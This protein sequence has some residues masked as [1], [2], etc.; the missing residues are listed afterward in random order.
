MSEDTPVASIVIPN[1]NG[2]H[3][4]ARCLSA[5]A[6]QTYQ[7]FECV[8]VD[9]G[10]VDGSCEFL[11]AHF[12][13][14][15]VIRLT[16]NTGFANACNVGIAGSRSPYI[17][18]LNN[19]TE[20][21]PNWLEN[22]VEAIESAHQDVAC[23]SSKLVKLDDPGIID[24]AGD[25]LTWR[26]GAFKRGHGCT[27]EE[28][29]RDE[30]VMLPCGGAALYRRSV[31]EELGGLDERFFAYLEDVDL[32]LRIRL[33]GYRCLFAANAKVLHK[34]HGSS[35]AAD[36]YVFL[37]T[38][39]RAYLFLK[40]IPGILLIKR[41]PSLFYGWLFF[42]IVHRGRRMYWRGTFAVLKNIVYVLK[43]RKEQRLRTTL[44]NT[45]IDELLSNPWPEVSLTMLVRNEY[46][47]LKLR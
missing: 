22:I 17:V 28:F 27:E 1:W 46:R 9:N 4:L 36:L 24:D 5:L 15:T 47:R 32:G 20:A 34:G 33:A 35:I 25:Y 8:V 39:N 31:L 19:D 7:D 14:V 29:N 38:R 16:T 26:G 44:S 40:N 2:R 21:C 23:V 45:E 37:T 12:P 18:L 42:L 30:E 41:F 10:S 13:D 6:A 11:E 43:E 3:M